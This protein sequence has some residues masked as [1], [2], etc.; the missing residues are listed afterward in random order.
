M[1]AGCPGSSWHG[2]YFEGAAKCAFRD[3]RRL[4]LALR[5]NAGI[6]VLS[7]TCKT[8]SRAA[9]PRNKHVMFGLTHITTN[10]R[11]PVVWGSGVGGRSESPSARVAHVC[12][13]GQGSSARERPCSSTAVDCSNP[14]Y[15]K[16]RQAST[17]GSA[18]SPFPSSGTRRRP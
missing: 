17:H 10:S 7:Q 6:F 11:G 14:G 8:D 4:E 18:R 2:A 15:N 13:V 16:R 5:L 12:G 9:K 1:Q 3:F